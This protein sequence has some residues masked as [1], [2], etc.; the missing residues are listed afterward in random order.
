MTATRLPP[1]WRDFEVYRTVI[2]G[3]KSTREAAEEFRLSQTRVCQIVERM[4]AWQAEVLPAESPLPADGL[5]RLS[6]NIACE[7]I[8]FLYG[9]A[10]A[11]WRRSQG[12]T[13]QTRNSGYDEF[14]TTK[15]SCGD[16]KYLL[17]ASRLVKASAQIGRH[18]GLALPEEEEEERDVAAGATPTPRG[19]AE[20]LKPEAQAKEHTGRPEARP[21]AHPIEDCSQNGHSQSAPVAAAPPPAAGTAESETTS[22]A[23][24]PEQAL[25]RRRLLAPV[26]HDHAAELA[27]SNGGTQIQ[28][29]AN[30]PGLRTTPLLTRQQRR[31]LQRAQRLGS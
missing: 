30:Q 11:A 20:P 14:V 16:P 29:T 31:K 2:V 5:L 23:L 4:R 12:E 19:R 1:S 25:A 9:E 28:L 15:F 7:R 10:M 26:Q 17:A 21:T 13:T 27:S 8:D 24:S 18:G 22:S 6:Q 3:G